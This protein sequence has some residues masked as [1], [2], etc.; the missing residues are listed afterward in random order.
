MQRATIAG[1]F[2]TCVTHISPCSHSL[3]IRDSNHTHSLMTFQI[4]SSWSITAHAGLYVCV[5]ICITH[6][7]NVNKVSSFISEFKM[8]NQPIHSM[9]WRH[10]S[11][12]IH[13]FYGYNKHW[14]H[15]QTYI[16][17]QWLQRWELLHGSE[18]DESAFFCLC[19]RSVCDLSVHQLGRLIGKGSLG[20]SVHYIEKYKKV[21]IGQNFKFWVIMCIQEFGPFWT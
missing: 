3:Q 14:E 8:T 10:P 17:F 4:N 2:H 20:W 13:L 9:S 12:T 21:V 5:C 16:P 18:D 15:L 7:I 19:M 6:T 1:I 11:W